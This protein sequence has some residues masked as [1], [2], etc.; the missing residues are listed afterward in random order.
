M[1]NQPRVASG[2]VVTQAEVHEAM[3]FAFEHLALVLEPGAR[4]ASP[5]CSRRPCR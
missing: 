4:C 3:R 5:P 1:I 2:L